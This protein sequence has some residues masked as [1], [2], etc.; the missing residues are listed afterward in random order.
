LAFEVAPNVDNW[1]VVAQ[2]ALLAQLM[3]ERSKGSATAADFAMRLLRRWFPVLGASG[4]RN[5]MTVLFMVVTR[6]A[7]HPSAGETMKPGVQPYQT[8][9]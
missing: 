3:L 9:S 7:S 1:L 5:P 4:D 6:Q 8:R 2:D